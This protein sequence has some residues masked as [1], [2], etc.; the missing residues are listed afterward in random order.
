METFKQ[1]L[2]RFT[3]GSIRG[4]PLNILASIENYPLSEIRVAKEQ[5]LYNLIFL[6]THAKS[7]QL[8]SIFLGIVGLEALSSILKISWMEVLMIRDSH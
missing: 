7:K 8:S 3:L 2:K 4:I 6:G 1:R 5:Q